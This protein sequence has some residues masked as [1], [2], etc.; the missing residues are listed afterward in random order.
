MESDSTTFERLRGELKVAV[1]APS[2]HERRITWVGAER[3]MAFA[4]D[5]KGRL[6][7][8]LLGGPLQPRERTV[9]ER[10]LHDTWKTAG[11]DHLDAN[12]LRLPDDDHYDAIAATILLELLDKGYEH[13]AVGAF[14]RTE[15]LIAL[16]LEP[17]RAENAALTGLAGELLAFAS[18][19]R[20]E[21]ASSGAFLDS[22]KGWTR[23]SRDFQL[24]SLGLEVKTSTTSA[25]R[26]HIQGWYQVEPGVAADGT[27]ET[28][29]YL[30]SIGIRWLPTDGP[31]TTVESL[32]KE[33]VGALPAQRRQSFVDAVRGYASLGLAIDENGAAGQAALRRP[34]ISTHERLYDLQDERIRLPRSD[35]FTAFTNLVS[36]SVTFEIELPER[37]RGDRNPVVGLTAGM[38]GLLA[39]SP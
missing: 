4:R 35:A 11:G 23:S 38:S 33:I 16:A 7:V 10:L 34:F 27:V 9:Q 8:F 2:A 3:R 36:D 22:W 37:V 28:G 5:A 18:M 29:L 32:V 6:E 1:R 26:H 24:G 14:R 19:I 21:P 20:L 39:I 15:P 25:S 31:G 13:E 17:A 30:L 12:R